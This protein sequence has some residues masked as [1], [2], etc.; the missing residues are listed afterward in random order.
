[1]RTIL[2]V[3][4]CSAFLLM[5]DPSL[6]S[7]PQSDALEEI[8]VTATRR[9]ERLQDVP[10]SVTAFSQ[11][12]LQQQGIVGFDG[13]ARET[14]GIVL[15]K[16][17]DNFNNFTA[18]GI[19]TNSYGA[20]L[21]STVAIY[22]DE[23]PISTIGNTT[24]LN[25][26]L[27]DVERVEFLR[28]PQGTLF[29]S[30]SLSGAL[31]ILTNSPNLTT[32]QAS[33]LV[34]YGLTGSDS[35][36]QRYNAMVNIPLIDNELALRVVGFYRHEDGYLNNLGT[37]IHNSNTLEDEGGR[38][39][40]LWVPTDRLS[41]KLLYSRE[42]SYPEDASLTSP[43]LG[44]YDR[45]SDEP[46]IYSGLLTNFNATID[47]RFDGAK[48]ISSSTYSRF[49]QRFIVDLANTFGGTVPFGLDAYGFQK[50]LVEETRLVS[51]S[52]GPFEWVIG[53]FFLG[54]HNN[55]PLLFR[56]SLPYL[57]AHD[58]T[59]LPD[60][61]FEKDYTY[62]DSREL[63]GFGDLTYHVN[64]QVWLTGGLRYGSARARG[65]TESGYNSNYF[66]NALFGIPGPL[67]IT[68]IPPGV[69]PT[70][71]A[72]KLS[73][74]ASISYKP[75]QS[76]T[77]YATVATGFRTPVVNA[78][79]G[80]VSV[81]N[82]KDLV[83]PAGASSDNLTNYEIG[84]KGR[85]FDGKVSSNVALYWIDWNN[86]QVQANRVS[87]SLQFATNIGGATSKG[88]EA[89]VH[90]V[91]VH[92]LTLGLNGSYDVA[93]VTKLSPSQAA[94]SG[95]VLG[96]RLSA[97][98]LQGAVTSRY[99]FDITSRMTGNF[100][101]D[102]EHVGGFPNGFSRVPGDPAVTS[103]SYQDTDTYNNVN[104]S[105]GIKTGQLSITSYVENLFNNHSF[106]YVHP[107]EF[108]ASRYG[109]LRP[110]TVGIRVGYDF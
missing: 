27:F 99:D 37:G 2:S 19:A 76:L 89:E 91:P 45:V 92:G 90:V 10:L 64:E 86:I 83:I 55:V 79:A 88:I 57:A 104:T 98:E 46:D 36:R 103:P 67:T 100:E 102:V 105:L 110:R 109:I 35:W 20:N 17:S 85:W 53:G 60:Q 56:S 82:P 42:D 87:D 22:I 63:A 25:P 23:L 15:N 107:E 96:A 94:I 38:A 7:D 13:L 70:A 81:V 71:E 78:N 24:V 44:R 47:Y 51:D 73:Y 97:P 62:T 93:R 65:V 8:T 58:I 72:S 69:G 74:K 3:A 31:R 54:R 52:D 32:F 30:G 49:D 6:A 12:A 11:E 16:Q 40:L 21:Q 101:V 39:A 80:T 43:A 28:G 50:T 77:T 61:Y 14:P 48:L 106:I 34:D 26:N 5:A 33:T 95:A 68:P 66:V 75:M 4:A 1:M 18:R 108:I 59:G 84:A 9:A 41:V 29:G